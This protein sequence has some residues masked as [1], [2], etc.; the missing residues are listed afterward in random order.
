MNDSMELASLVCLSALTLASILFAAQ[1]IVFSYIGSIAELKKGNGIDKTIPGDSGK[2]FRTSRIRGQL[3]GIMSL[4]RYL[5]I[6]FLIS[7]GVSF[8]WGVC[9]KLEI[10]DTVLWILSIVSI[11]LFLLMLVFFLFIVLRL[12]VAERK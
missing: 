12:G 4:M 11:S 7:A 3:E 9:I 1:A 5:I 8:S 2:F 10:C 6:L